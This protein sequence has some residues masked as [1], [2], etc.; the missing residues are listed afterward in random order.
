VRTLD[1]LM[2]VEP[3][4]GDAFKGDIVIKARAADGDGRWGVALVSGVPGE[5]GTT[6]FHEG[7]AE[8]FFIL[9]G[10][11]E[12]LGAS[13]RTPLVAGAFVLIPPDT[14][15]GLRIVGER[16]ASW[17]AIWPARLDGMPEALA[18]IGDDSVAEALVRRRHGIEP[19]RDRRSEVARPWDEAAP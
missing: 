2:V 13:S 16:R 3:G 5:G 10:E 18:A 12:L 17:L 1:G 8:A 11:V 6:H 4:G 9:E 14:E 7:E 15:H 19:G